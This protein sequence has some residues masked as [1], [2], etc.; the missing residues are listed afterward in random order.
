MSNMFI[1]S[2]I[3]EI[4]E[5]GN[6]S[7]PQ[8]FLRNLK[9]RDSALQ[10]FIGF[11]ENAVCLVLY[12]EDFVDMQHAEITM[13]RPACTPDA[14]DARLR[15]RFGFVVPAS[16]GPG[17]ILPIPS[18][19]RAQCHIGSNVLLVGTGLRLEIWDL[20]SVMDCGSSDLRSLAQLHINNP[21][22]EDRN[23]P[24]L[25]LPESHCFVATGHQPGLCV[26][27]VPGLRAGLNS[28]N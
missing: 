16:I 15:R 23:E 9:R 3:C 13:A 22:M 25:P 12:D 10:M 14:Y 2:N 5:S 11:H 17:G 20:Q 24:C 6:L 19:L 4:T 18:M 8:A 26:R 21:L 7:I 1:G 27:P 28:I